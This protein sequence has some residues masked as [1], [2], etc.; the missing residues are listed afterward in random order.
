MAK[1]KEL[2]KL[3]Y[4]NLA[5]IKWKRGAKEIMGF[6]SML[7][8]FYVRKTLQLVSLMKMKYINGEKTSKRMIFCLMSLT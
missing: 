5:I 3:W 4:L 7:M 8:K 6:K 1:I 2:L